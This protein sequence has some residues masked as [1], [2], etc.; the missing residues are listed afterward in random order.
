MGNGALARQKQYWDRQANDFD[1]IYSRAKSPVGILIDSLF[2]RDMYQRFDY[3][4]RHAEPIAGRTFLDVGCGTGWY[5]LE[6]A[7]RYAKRVVGLDISKVMTEICRRRALEEHLDDRTSFVQ[8]DLLEYRPHTD[9]DVGIGIG[10]FD[11]IRDPLPVLAGLRECCRDRAIMSFPRLWTWRAPVRKIRLGMRNCDVY[12]YTLAR[13]AALLKAAGFHAYTFEKLGQL[14]C[15]TAF[16]GGRR[17]GTGVN[18]A[19]NAGRA[20]GHRGRA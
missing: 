2:R 13:I 11:Y 5:S 6:L 18:P 4:L 14:Y 8:T 12:F 3:T 16:S 20:S 17:S 19:Q 15:V 7:R 1:S 9:F 10:L